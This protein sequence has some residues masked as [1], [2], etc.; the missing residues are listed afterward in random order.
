MILYQ[1]KKFESH[2]Q[3]ALIKQLEAN[4]LDTLASKEK[5]ESRIVINA[6]DQLMQGIN[7]GEFDHLIKPLLDEFDIPE[8][9]FESYVSMFSKASLEKKVAIELGSDYDALS[10]LMI[11][12]KEHIIP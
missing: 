11:I 1:G 8:E 12:T 3:E 2:N 4:C 6:C 9:Q 10:P 5:L 7:K